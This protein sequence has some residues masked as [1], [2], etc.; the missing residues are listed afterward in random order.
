VV[1]VLLVLTRGGRAPDDV[2]LLGAGSVVAFGPARETLAHAPLREAFGVEVM[3]VP[4]GD[5]RLL[6]VPIGRTPR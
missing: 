5:G 6:P 2:L 3:M 1:C 4:D